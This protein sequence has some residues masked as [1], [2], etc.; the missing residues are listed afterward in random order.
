MYNQNDLEYMNAALAQAKKSLF[1][2]NPNPRVGCVLVKDGEIIG[3]GF[4]QVVGGDHAE[5]MALKDAKHKGYDVSDSCA[6]VTLEPCCHQ[7][8]TPPCT[9]SLIKAKIKTIFVAINT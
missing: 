1:I 8:R 3:C 7:G 2:S 4:T 6:Y 9:D 5:I